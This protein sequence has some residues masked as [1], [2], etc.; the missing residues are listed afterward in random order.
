MSAASR[1]L[2]ERKKVL[3]SVQYLRAVA[4]LSVVLFHQ[5]IP[6]FVVYGY[7]GVDVFFILSGFIM[8]CLTQ[9]RVVS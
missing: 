5:T 4:A 1:R 8:I 3:W 9:D 7:H 2:R 6:L